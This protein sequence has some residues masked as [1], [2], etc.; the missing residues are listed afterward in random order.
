MPNQLLVSFKKDPKSKKHLAANLLGGSV[1]FNCKRSRL[2]LTI[3][4]THTFVCD[5]QY[6]PAA[7]VAVRMC[8]TLYSRSNCENARYRYRIGFGNP[9][10]SFRPSI[11]E[12]KEATATFKLAQHDDD[13]KRVCILLLLLLCLVT[14]CYAFPFGVVLG[15][16]TGRGG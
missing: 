3:A 8:V 11:E 6:I 2:L 1:R 5:I 12:N 13:D 9:S 15:Q 14:R 4:H 16:R 7:K 10:L